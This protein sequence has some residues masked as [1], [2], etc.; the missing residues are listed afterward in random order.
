MQNLLESNYK[1]KLSFYKNHKNL[2]LFGNFN[3]CIELANGK[4]VCLLH[5]DDILLPNY[6]K[7]MQERIK[8]I[9]KNTSLISHRAIYFGN[10]SLI[11]YKQDENIIKSYIKHKIPILFIFLKAIK[12]IFIKKIIYSIFHIKTY[13]E[14]DTR[15]FD[16]ICKYNPLHPSALLHNKEQCIKLGG[17]NDSFYP[18]ADW[19][20]HAIC[21]KYTKVYQ[22]SRFLSKYRWE[23]N[24]SFEYQTLLQGSMMDLV[25]IR[26]NL[27]NNSI[28]N[29]IIYH[30]YQMIYKIDDENLREK[31]IENLKFQD[32]KYPKKPS[33]LDKII[34]KIHTMHCVELWKAENDIEKL[35]EK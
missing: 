35:G 21:A 15:D 4:W 5:D 2:G 17:Y 29:T 6:L 9:D 19:F 26:D 24:T 13:K 33:M 31:I 23:I 20:F 8:I 3:R 11:N 22:D 16:Y 28:K 32:F 27:I 18:S 30:K 14:F 34:Y 1:N 7:E 10:L 25:F 12:Q